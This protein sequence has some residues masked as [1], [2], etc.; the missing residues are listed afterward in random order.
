MPVRVFSLPVV[1]GAEPLLRTCSF[2]V[3]LSK[4]IVIG[5]SNCRTVYKAYFQA[6]EVLSIQKPY[7][8]T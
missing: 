1:M 6:M 5:P 3:S 8:H 7:M 2:L 4:P